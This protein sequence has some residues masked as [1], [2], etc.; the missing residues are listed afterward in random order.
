MTTTRR[1]FLQKGAVFT[2]AAATGTLFSPFLRTAQAGPASNSV[3]FASGEPL[4]GN[5]DPT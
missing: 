2:G 3:V 5:W 1:T 4:T